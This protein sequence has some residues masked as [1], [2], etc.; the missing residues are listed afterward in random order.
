MFTQVPNEAIIAPL[1]TFICFNLG[2]LACVFYLGVGGQR[3]LTLLR[4]HAKH[5]HQS[6]FSS[7]PCG[8]KTW[9]S[10]CG[11]TKPMLRQSMSL[12]CGS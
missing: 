2:L 1:I 8:A 4:D 3:C 6:E 10:S 7:S 9:P 12:I 11:I 5:F